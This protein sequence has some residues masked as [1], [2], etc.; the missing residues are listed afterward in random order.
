MSLPLVPVGSPFPPPS[1]THISPALVIY[2][3]A[4]LPPDR[5]DMAKRHMH[6]LGYH[7][8][9]SLGNTIAFKPSLLHAVVATHGENTVGPIGKS[10]MLNLTESL[11]LDLFDVSLPVSA[12]WIKSSAAASN[13]RG[14]SSG[15]SSDTIASAS[16]DIA[17][18]TSVGLGCT[19]AAVILLVS[20]YVLR[21]RCSK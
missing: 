21:W 18:A 20:W 10:M 7:T 19:S 11:R 2:E 17:W 12:S 5:A 8:I 6:T 4:N 16:S 3:H 15:S 13:I 1:H 14:G 9:S